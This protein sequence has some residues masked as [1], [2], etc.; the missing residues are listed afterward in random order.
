MGFQDKLET[1]LLQP[2]RHPENS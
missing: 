2:F 1:K